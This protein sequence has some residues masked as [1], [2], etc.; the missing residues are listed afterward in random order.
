MA[1]LLQAGSL[2]AATVANGLMAGLFAAFAYAVMPGLGR[3]DDRT[4]VGAFQSIDRAII[5]PWFVTAFIGSVGFTL[6]AGLLHLREGARPVLPWIVAALAMSVAVV[7]ITVRINVPLNNEIVAAG[8]P[9][10]ITDL[11]TVR[12]RFEATWVRWNLVRAVASTAALACLAW[13]LVEHGRA[14]PP[15]GS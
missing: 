12:G 8:H 10:K 2:V 11:A 4:F 15:G 3:T 9:D 14:L 6:L 5:N 1:Q 13:A 7:V